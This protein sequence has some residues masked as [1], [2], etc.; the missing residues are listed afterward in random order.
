MVSK[1]NLGEESATTFSQSKYADNTER[2]FFETS[3]IHQTI[4]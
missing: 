2:K 1:Q 3:R 4:A